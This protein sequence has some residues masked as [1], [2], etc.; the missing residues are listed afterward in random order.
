MKRHPGF[1]TSLIVLVWA[2]ALAAVAAAQAGRFAVQVEAS[3]SR[4]DA[5][6]RAERLK[7]HGIEAYLV[8]SLVPGKGHFYRV[9][10]GDFADRN[11]AVRHGQELK[12]RGV[13]RDFFVAAYEAPVPEAPSEP[14]Q[15]EATPP[16]TSAQP[17]ALPAPDDSSQPAAT[18]SS[19]VDS[20]EAAPTTTPPS[21]DPPAPNGYALYQ[22]ADVGYSFE[23]PQDWVGRPLSASEQ[24]AHKVTAGAMFK[25]ARRA[26]FLNA[27]FNKLDRANRSDHDNEVVVD[28]ILESMA[29][30]NATE[31]L[32]ALSRRVV[33]DGAQIKTFLEL[34]AGFRAPDQSAP[35]EFL[36]KCVIIR[37]SKGI[38]LLVAFY[39]R[40]APPS[41]A[42]DADHIVQTAAV[43]D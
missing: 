5:E 15:A 33:H 14:D 39:A 25:S 35:L 7:A 21:N 16:A 32:D 2:L 36:G 41:A 43:P 24:L 29:S 10:V 26:D 31:H 1:P 42:I 18:T 8:E 40:D 3:P 37:A 30:G 38:L 22:D 9:R 19:A 34:E 23:Y 6:A 20:F 12:A 11:A 28:L 27:T 17:P 13:V 4:A